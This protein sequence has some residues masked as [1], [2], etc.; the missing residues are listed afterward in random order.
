MM[1]LLQINL[2]FCTCVFSCHAVITDTVVVTSI[3]PFLTL[4]VCPTI[5]YA[6]IYKIDTVCDVIFCKYNL[7][8][9][10]SSVNT[11]SM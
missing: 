11:I 6:H 4:F 3:L 5:I 8:V 7:Y 10:L 2:P 1:L 9:M